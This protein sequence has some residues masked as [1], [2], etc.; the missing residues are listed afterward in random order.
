LI[1]QLIDPIRR[2]PNLHQLPD[3]LTIQLPNQLPDYQIIQLPN[4]LPDYP[5]TQL[6]D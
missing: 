1:E 4:Q 2:F 5:I 3:C 6:P